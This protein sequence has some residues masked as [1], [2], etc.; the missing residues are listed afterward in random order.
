MAILSGNLDQDAHKH[1]TRRGWF[2]GWYLPQGTPFH[3]KDFEM[4]WGVHKKGWKRESFAAQRTAKSITILVSG[5]FITKFK[6]R[7]VTLSRP[8]DYVYFSPRVYHITEA[9]EDSVVLTIR[10]PSIPHDQAE[11]K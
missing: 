11:R 2:V 5:K 7:K 6:A 3:S 1:P 8:G 4:K 10:W 9:R